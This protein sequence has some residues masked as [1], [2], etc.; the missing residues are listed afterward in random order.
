MMYQM[1]ALDRA[2]EANEINA[3]SLPSS[4]F[5]DGD[6]ETE[7]LESIVD[8]RMHQIHTVLGLLFD[9]T[10]CVTDKLILWDLDTFLFDSGGTL[11]DFAR[12]NVRLCFLFERVVDHISH[13]KTFEDI[14]SSV[15]TDL[16]LQIE[17]CDPGF[18]EKT[19]RISSYS[20]QFP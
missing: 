4:L 19:D 15:A 20:T 9:N 14:F 12:D 10:E 16:A 7:R 11:D 1:S 3:S 13:V 6:K 5:L 18:F 17:K 8:Y 2:T